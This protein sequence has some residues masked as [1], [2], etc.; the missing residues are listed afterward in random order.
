MGVYSPAFLS[1][2]SEKGPPFASGMG[3]HSASA[4]VDVAMMVAV[5]RTVKWVG[6]ASRLGSRAAPTAS[7]WP[8]RSIAS[9]P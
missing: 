1:P 3:P 2:A 9:H 7:P 4:T 6:E 5:G 8:W